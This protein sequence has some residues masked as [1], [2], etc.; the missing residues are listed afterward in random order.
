MPSFVFKDQP[1]MFT[2]TAYNEKKEKQKKGGDDFR[3]IFQHLFGN[4]I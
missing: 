2:V 1:T 3:V 4:V